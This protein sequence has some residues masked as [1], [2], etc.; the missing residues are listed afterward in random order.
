LVTTI[1]GRYQLD[2]VHIGRGG[3]GEVWGAT[4]TRLRRRVAVKFISFPDGQPDHELTSRFVRESQLTARMDHPGVPVIYDAAK[5]ADGPFEGRL[6][7]VMQL[8][9]GINVDDLVA[10]HDPLPVGWAVAIAAQTCAVLSYAHGK[11]LIHRDL[12]PSN[13]MLSR[14]GMLKVL[15][16]GLAVALDASD[17]S[18]ITRTN[19]MVGTLA[20]M[21]PEQFRN[22]PS[23]RSDFYALGC[24]LHRMLTG[25]LPFDGPT[26]ASIMHGQIYE[27]PTP[28]RE[29]RPDVPAGLEEVVLRL[30][31]KNPEERP[32]TADEIYALLMPYLS[33]LGELPG[34]VQPGLSASRMYTNVVGRV[35]AA[36]S[37][38]V[39]PA[40]PPNPPSAPAPEP[41]SLGDVARARRQAERL[42][43]DSRFD[44]AA[45]MLTRIAEK[46]G[47][48]LGAEHS[49][50]IGLRIDLANVL[51]T[52]GDYKQAAAGFHSVSED[53]ARRDGAD[54]DLVL[55]LR[56]QEATC[57]A[58][59]G[60]SDLALRQLE[61]LLIDER[62]VYG[63]DDDRVTELRKQIGLLQHGIG[64]TTEAVRGL[65]QLTSDLERRHGPNNAEVQELHEAIARMK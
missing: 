35:F 63:G 16:F 40:P 29:L 22:E 47:P 57:H 62:R 1:A 53:L 4:D 55:R 46:A 48:L 49:D 7:L 51:F 36:P 2:P 9:D 59:Y 65:E 28:V 15:D 17:R 61:R 56:F 12:K 21:S 60:N 42:T 23:A 44:E 3:M 39:H 32:A 25:R 37:T 5:V 18:K 14:D 11:Q 30:L 26:E 58:A 6:Y 10:E 33:T 20:Y 45:Q 38:A 52:G 50:V 13:L 24:V 27:E 34:T 19:Q 64:R 31:A 43:R 8:I 54:S 41:I